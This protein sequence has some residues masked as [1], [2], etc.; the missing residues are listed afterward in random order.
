M[1]PC[2][3][4]Q[5]SEDNLWAL[6]LSFYLWVL[7]SSSGV[8]AGTC[9]CWGIVPALASFTHRA[10][11]REG[12]VDQGSAF[13]GRELRMVFICP[14]ACKTSEWTN[15]HTHKRNLFQ[16]PYVTQKP[17]IITPRPFVEKV[18]WFPETMGK[19]PSVSDE[20]SSLFLEVRRAPREMRTWKELEILLS[21]INPQGIVP[22]GP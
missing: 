19:N 7:L 15:N 18:Y 12:S 5:R 11:H 21:M 13:H 9:T 14:K 1:N 22:A 16:K 17:K 4:V 10:G 3:H 20:R 8:V 6:T 2:A